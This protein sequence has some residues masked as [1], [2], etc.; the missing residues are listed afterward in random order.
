VIHLVISFETFIST[1]CLGLQG[2]PKYEVE[3]EEI[4]QNQYFNEIPTSLNP[5]GSYHQTPFWGNKPYRY[6]LTKSY[7]ILFLDKEC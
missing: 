6:T 1:L 3:Q 2:Y 7:T 5:F 4:Y